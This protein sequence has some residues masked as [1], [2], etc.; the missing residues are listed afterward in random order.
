LAALAREAALQAPMGPAATLDLQAPAMA[1]ELLRQ[2]CSHQQW[3]LPLL[4][5]GRGHQADHG[6]PRYQNA[7]EMYCTRRPQNPGRKDNQR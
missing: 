4:V 5:D 1:Q 6:P 7:K 2:P 3:L